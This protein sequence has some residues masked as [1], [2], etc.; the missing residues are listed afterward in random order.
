MKGVLVGIEGIDAAGKRTQS[1]LL[2]RWFRSKGIVSDGMSF[3][4]YSTPLGSEIRRF[5]HGGRAYPPEVRHM[6]FAANRWESKATIERKLA[7]NDAVVVNRYTESNL[8]YGTAHGLPLDWLVNLERGLPK[9]DLVVVLDAP[10]SSTYSRR[11][12]VKDRYESDAVLQE[13]TRQAYL[14]LASKFGWHVIDGARSVRST[15]ADVTA[16]VSGLVSRARATAS[17]GAAT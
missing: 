11:A 9:T 5:L 13:R 4:E 16:A 8:A 3:P 17:G 1:D 15:H 10:P 7:A 6:L 2:H 12:R 14:S